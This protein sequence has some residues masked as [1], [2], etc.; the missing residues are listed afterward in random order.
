LRFGRL[1]LLN[2]LNVAMIGHPMK[3]S[4]NL[5]YEKQSVCCCAVRR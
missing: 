2:F 3:C 5:E 4:E 1:S